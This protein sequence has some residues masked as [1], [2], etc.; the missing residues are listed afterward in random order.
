M[1][2]SRR[3]RKGERQRQI[4]RDR[5]RDRED[6]QRQRETDRQRE[7]KR[8]TKTGTEMKRNT[9]E[10]ANLHVA[11]LR[12]GVRVCQCHGERSQLRGAGHAHWQGEACSKKESEGFSPATPAVWLL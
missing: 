7:T 11:D 5:K 2:D 3:E 1:N 8:E 10:R 9:S 12:L 4:N 6:E